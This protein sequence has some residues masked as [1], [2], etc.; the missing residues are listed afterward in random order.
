MK[1]LLQETVRQD[2]RLSNLRKLKEMTMR[3]F[4]SFFFSDILLLLMTLTGSSAFCQEPVD[5]QVRQERLP[6]IVRPHSDNVNKLVPIPMH[7][8]LVA[9]LMSSKAMPAATHR[10]L[11]FRQVSGSDFSE[12][13]CWNATILN[14]SKRPGGLTLTLR[15]SPGYNAKMDTSYLWEHYALID[16]SITLVGVETPPPMGRMSIGF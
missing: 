16:G 4:R 13:V 3:R 7:D 9:T 8:R 15:V 6:L 11:Y 14:V 10:E 5:G 12:I 2:G 1:L